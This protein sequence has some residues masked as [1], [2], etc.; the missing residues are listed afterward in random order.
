MSARPPLYVLHAPGTNRDA[1]A[2][3]AAEVAGFEPTIVHVAH[4]VDATV[5]LDKSAAIVV[6][7]GFSYG[8][9]LG[10]GVR[11]ALDLRLSL[12]QEL[13]TFVDDGGYVLGICNGFQALVKSGLLPGPT[14]IGDEGSRSAGESA[15]QKSADAVGG[16]ER[17]VTLTQNQR[18]R[19]ECRWVHLEP[20]RNATASWL[21]DIED[22][23]HCPV[24]HGEGRFAVAD[25]ATL[26]AI[27]AQN[28]AA[29]RY[30]DANG[31]PVDGAY[32]LNP[33]GSVGD[34]AGICDA[35][36]RVVGLMPH[37]EDHILAV[38]RPHG[39]DGQLGLA[40][41]SALRDAVG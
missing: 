12:A 5:P 11:F 7:G 26:A 3:W 40:L 35:T 39:T 37:P 16:R 14:S 2:A 38:Q 32:P 1:E 41:F 21:A 34:I 27:E 9:A 24:A 6:P 29:F 25:E 19:F 22:L 17:T 13:R 18:G 4:A 28:L 8:D 20:N 23:I 31:Q 30:V 33:N 15:P 36:G 10:A